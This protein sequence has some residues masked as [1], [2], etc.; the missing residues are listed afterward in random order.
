MHSST[1]AKIVF[2]RLSRLLIACSIAWLSMLVGQASV[3]LSS[4]SH[5]LST[6]F[7]PPAL[8]SFTFCN[9]YK[10]TQHIK[11]FSHKL[12]KSNKSTNPV[13]RFLQQWNMNA[14]NIHGWLSIIYLS[15]KYIWFF[16]D[17][18]VWG[19]GCLYRPVI[20]SRVILGKIII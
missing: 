4:T 17:I 19:Y 1:T 5:R 11:I 13:R 8:F 15:W 7:A 6:K 2:N 3:F 12:M 14:F 18:L 9:N 10:I 20:S 16:G